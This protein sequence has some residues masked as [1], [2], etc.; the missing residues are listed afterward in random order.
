MTEKK[1]LQLKSVMTSG[2]S[3]SVTDA[4]AP[5]DVVEAGAGDGFARSMASSGRDGAG[6]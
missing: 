5:A 6:F 4:G 3:S 1:F 2:S